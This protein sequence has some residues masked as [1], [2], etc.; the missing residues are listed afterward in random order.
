MDYCLSI[1]CMSKKI[2][3][4]YTSQNHL[5]EEEALYAASLSP[6]QCWKEAVELIRK[7]YPNK[8]NTKKITIVQR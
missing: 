3:K 1:L 4:I 5:A 6:I 7:V 8:I 2:I